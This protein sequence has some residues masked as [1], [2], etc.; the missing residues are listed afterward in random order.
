MC[1]SRPTGDHTFVV[2]APRVVHDSLFGTTRVVDARGAATSRAVAMPLA[3]LRAVDVRK[4]DVA[5]TLVLV[6]GIVGVFALLGVAVSNA[7]DNSFQGMSF[8]Q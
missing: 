6:G 1:K 7:M 5:G 3:E 2:D 4:F 8:S